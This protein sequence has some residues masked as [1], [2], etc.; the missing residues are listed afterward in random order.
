MRAYGSD[1][2]MKQVQVGIADE[3]NIEIIEGLSRRRYCACCFTGFN[4]QQFR[5]PR[6]MGGMGG[7]GGSQNT[8]GRDGQNTAEQPKEGQM[9]I[10]GKKENLIK[11]RI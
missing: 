2:E 5:R 10:E 4:K 8:T 11:L 3:T 9:T 6:F 7:M 1:I